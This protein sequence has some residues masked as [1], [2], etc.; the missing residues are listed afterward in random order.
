MS[1]DLVPSPGAP[2]LVEPRK[3]QVNGVVREVSV[4]PLAPVVTRGSL[5]DI[6]FDNEREAP[7]EAVLSRKDADGG[8][9]DVTAAEFAAEV[10]A[11]AKGL[12]AEGLKPGDRLAV[13][14]RT[15][16]EW[17]LIDFAAW[18]AG[19]VT[20]PIY[21]TSSA[22][23]ARWILE[24]SGA[25]AC[26]VES[27]EQAR[28]ISQERRQLPGLDHL[29]VFDTG[30]VGQLRKTG[31]RARIPDAVLNARRETLTPDSVATL[32]YTSGTTG[33]PK[34]CVL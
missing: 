31:E 3:K 4:P 20:V 14:A 13:M 22:F 7:G 18:A 28:L 5:A 21:P 34:G 29:W 32:I 23:Q 27:A 24:N 26:V 8:W 15:T 33:R 17:T 10:R 19:L 30:A 6:P 16:Y 1:A 12:I 9:L 11:V 2:A 25:A